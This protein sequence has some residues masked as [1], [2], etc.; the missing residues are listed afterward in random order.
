M[1]IPSGGGGVEQTTMPLTTQRALLTTSAVLRHYRELLELIS[2]IPDKDQRYNALQQARS[3]LRANRGITNPMEASDKL[4]EMVSKISF[5]RMTTP[6]DPRM[7]RSSTSGTMI[8][9]PVL[10]SFFYIASEPTRCLLRPPDR[11]ICCPGW[12][13]GE[14]EGTEQGCPCR[15]WNNFNGRS[16]CLS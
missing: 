4:K 2:L 1:G 9:L 14:R 6:R 13:A 10:R 7:K 3:G 16:P 8:I 15:R 12:G 11:D 5:L